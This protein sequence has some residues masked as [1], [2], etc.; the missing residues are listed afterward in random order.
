M[1]QKIHPLKK[2]NLPEKKFNWKKEIKVFL[3]NITIAL[4]I[5]FLIISNIAQAYRVEGES[6]EPGLLDNE[7]IIVSKIIYK[8]REIKRGEV[9]IFRYPSKPQ[10]YFI[11]RIIGLPGETVFIEKGDIYVNNQ[12][13]N[14]PYL[15]SDFK[16]Q[17]TT[18][19]TFIPSG[20]YYVLGDHRTSSND[21]R[22]GWLVPRKYIIGKAV[23]RYW[24]LK[25]T[26][27]L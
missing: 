2:M 4:T 19:S 13:L 14:E 3:I 23:F 22:N 9:V 16:S 8:L 21:S 25:R 24:P 1:E 10:K 20:Y 6:M 27:T 17:E 15:K 5:S 26:G 12:K 7:R 18:P 11:K